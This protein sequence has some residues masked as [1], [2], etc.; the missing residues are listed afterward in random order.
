MKPSLPF[1]CLHPQTSHPA[2]RVRGQNNKGTA[3]IRQATRTVRARA[4]ENNWF[5]ASNKRTG[6]NGG[7]GALNQYCYN[8]CSTSGAYEP[9][10]MS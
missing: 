9:R 2:P 8:A 5:T 7:G 3:G 1:P 4:G 10:N 6:E